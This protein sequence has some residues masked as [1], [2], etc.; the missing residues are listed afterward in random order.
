[1]SQN[2]LKCK[3]FTPSHHH[4]DNYA[5]YRPKLIS[6]TLL[7]AFLIN[8]TLLKIAILPH[9]LFPGLRKLNQ[10][11]NTYFDTSKCCLLNGN[12]F[13]T[14]IFDIF[15]ADKTFGSC[16]MSVI[17]TIDLFEGLVFSDTPQE[18]WIYIMYK[19]E[20]SFSYY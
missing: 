12:T 2:I 19:S 17:M 18:M 10:S 4:F 8:S 7:V 6:K 16:L 14:Y 9:D 20:V 11:N 1:M 3:H 13:T 15:S 5:N